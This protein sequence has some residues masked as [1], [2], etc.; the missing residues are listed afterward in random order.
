MRVVIIGNAGSGKTTLARRLCAQSGAA[1]LSLDALAFD[2]GAARKPLD[3]SAALLR[4]FIEAHERW[5]IEGCYAD[6]ASLALPSCSELIFLNP[7]VE[8]CIANCRARNWEPDKFESAEAQNATLESLIEWV[9]QYEARDDE[10]GL[11]RHRALF[12][13]FEGPKREVDA[14][15]ITSPNSP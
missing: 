8:A 10:Y 7:G 14:A 12:D 15:D 6:L 9:A 4:R 1:H 11:Q 5:V 3:E 2:E 13:A